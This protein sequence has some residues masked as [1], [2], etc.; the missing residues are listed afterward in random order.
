M[1]N[2]KPAVE[3]FDL[4]IRQHMAAHPGTTYPDAAVAVAAAVPELY[5]AYTSASSKTPPATPC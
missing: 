1:T 2:V 3:L 5:A 4:A